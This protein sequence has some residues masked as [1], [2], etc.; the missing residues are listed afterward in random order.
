MIEGCG[1]NKFSSLMSGVRVIEQ[2]CAQE[3]GGGELAFKVFM[4]MRWPHATKQIQQW[5]AT[6]PATLSQI[7]PVQ[8]G[9]AGKER[10]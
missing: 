1:V 4:S 6:L 2:A 5:I 10:E 9:D 3:T 7:G 8:G